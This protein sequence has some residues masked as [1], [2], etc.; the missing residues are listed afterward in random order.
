MVRREGDHDD[1]QIFFNPRTKCCTFSPTLPNFLAGRIL[2]DGS[3][4][5]AEGRA[6]VERRLAK[7]LGVT[8]LGIGQTAT[9]ALWYNHVAAGFGRSETLLCPHYVGDPGRCAIWPHRNSVCSTFF[10]KHDRGAAGFHFWREAL[11]NLLKSIE[12]ALSRWCVLELGVGGTALERL[13]ELGD[14][15]KT[16]AEGELEGT[17]KSTTYRAL[18]DRWIGQERQFFEECAAKVDGL[19]WTDVA[20][21]CGPQVRLLA[22]MTQDVYAK[23]GHTAPEPALRCGSFKL[24]S[25]RS[26]VVCLSTYCDYDPI[27]I[28]ARLLGVLQHFGGQ[29]TSEAVAAI[30]AR[31]NV[32]LDSDLV[33]K[34]TDFGL[35]VP[36]EKCND[37]L[38]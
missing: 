20:Q 26:D 38:T 25:M 34:L 17:V 37:S 1:R 30:A 15:C 31:E 13:L 29:P 10:C 32:T 28:P 5:M 23:L 18:W 35:L 16:I 24:V 21:I 2:R 27:E 12:W 8:P 6:S 3:P 11:E 14:D 33:R 9:Y 22:R 19:R 4:E 36:A 7:M